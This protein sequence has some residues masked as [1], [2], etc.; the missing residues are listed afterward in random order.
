M[1]FENNLSFINSL[2]VMIEDYFLNK[3]AKALHK[4]KFASVLSEIRA[5]YACNHT[6]DHEWF[7][8]DLKTQEPELN[9]CTISFGY[10]YKTR[11]S[12]HILPYTIGIETVL[13][14]VVFDSGRPILPAYLM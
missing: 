9:C 8:N 11:G 6:K 13:A 3:K 7:L 10:S 12:V 5:H 14:D 2:W 4:K 1:A